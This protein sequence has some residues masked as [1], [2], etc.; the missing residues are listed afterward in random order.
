MSSCYLNRPE[1][2]LFFF[3]QITYF[4]LRNY[5][6]PNSKRCILPLNE[7]LQSK[8][9]SSEPRGKSRVSSP[10]VVALTK[11]FRPELEEQFQTFCEIKAKEY[12]IKSAEEF[13]QLTQSELLVILGDTFNAKD[14]YLDDEKGE[15][16]MAVSKEDRNEFLKLLIEWSIGRIDMKFYSFYAHLSEHGKKD[17]LPFLDKDLLFCIDSIRIKEIHGD[18]VVKQKGQLILDWYLDSVIPPTIQIDI[19]HDAHQKLIRSIGRILQNAHSTSDFQPFD[20]VRAQLVKEMLPYWAGFKHS[21]KPSSTRPL[22]KLEKILKERLED[23]FNAKNPAPDDFKLPALNQ[24]RKEVNGN[25]PI[26]I[27]FSLTTGIKYKDE[28]TNQLLSEDPNSVMSNAGGA[29]G[30]AV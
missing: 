1:F 30:T 13:A 10:F 2:S 12:D 28:K 4:L 23:F 3:F 11:E 22:T 5:L 17:G 18:E 14:F 21:Y 24:K 19:N 7:R 27:A 29:T 8:F 26:Q 15:G 9:N 25:G 6:E 16:K 20:D